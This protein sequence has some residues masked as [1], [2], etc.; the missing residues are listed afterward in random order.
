[1]ERWKKKKKNQPDPTQSRFF[2]L[3][4]VELGWIDPCVL[5]KYGSL[6]VNSDTLIDP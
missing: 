4:W 6:S 5:N 2:G 3:S 1:M